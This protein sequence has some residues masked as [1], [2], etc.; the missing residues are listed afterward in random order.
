VGTR[1]ATPETFAID[2]IQVDDQGR[3]FKGDGRRV[4]DYPSYGAP[5][6]SVAEGEVVALHD[7]MGESIP[8]ERNPNLAKPEDFGGNY[9][10]V[11]IKPD[12]YVVYGHLQAG[13][14]PVKVGDHVA[15]GAPIGK[16]GNTGNSSNPHLHFGLLDSADFLTANSLP[17]VF[18]RH[19]IRAQIT[20]GDETHLTIAPVG[21]D[22]VNAHP[23]VYGIADYE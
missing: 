14:I 4:E 8:F 9:V 3:F 5:I 2:W 23:M 13:S 15:A 1:I 18:A 16:L 7:G 17:F 20:G 22:V 21:R 19:R 12:V 10:L 11:H 6:R